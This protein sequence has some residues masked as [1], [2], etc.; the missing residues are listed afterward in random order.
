MSLSVRQSPQDSHHLPA[1]I[2]R[3]VNSLDGALLVV[4]GHERRE[5]ALWRGVEAVSRCQQTEQSLPRWPVHLRCGGLRRD[6]VRM[7]ATG[8]VVLWKT[9]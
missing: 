7:P 2:R 8:I 1:A 6:I 3:R 5:P 9:F 4:V